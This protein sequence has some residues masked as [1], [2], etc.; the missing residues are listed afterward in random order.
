MPIGVIELSVPPATMISASPYWIVR[1][2]S[3]IE[4]VPV[5][6]A[7]T[8][9]MLLPLRLQA[10]LTFPAA[11]LE[12]ISGTNSGATLEGPFSSSLVCSRSIA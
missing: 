7:V 9:L 12:I 5:A 3:P 2:A 6:H 8:T 10:M 1:N 11:M 4:L